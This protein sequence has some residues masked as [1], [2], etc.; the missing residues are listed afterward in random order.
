MSEFQFEWDIVK[1]KENLRSHDISFEEAQ[2][3]FYDD[4]A[5]EFYDDEHSEWEDRFLLLGLSFKLRLVMVCHCYREKES[6][7]RIISARKATAKEA[8]FY[9]R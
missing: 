1:A 6:M 2:T 7:I 8:R 9:R 5:R 3:V 4:F